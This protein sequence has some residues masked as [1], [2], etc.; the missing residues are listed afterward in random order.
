MIY[1]EAPTPYRPAPGDGP[2][3]FLAGGIT[4]CPDWQADARTL[5]ADAPIVVLNPRR[6]HY[7]PADGDTAEQQ[8][9]WEYHHLHLA[10][11]TLFWFPRCDPRTTVQPITLLELGTALAETRLQGRLITVGADP[12]F[13]RRHDL[14]LQLRHGAPALNLHDTLP[15]TIAGALRALNITA[16]G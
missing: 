13:P 5:L 1:V 7:N 15:A 2:S 8:V 12:D 11:L 10:D 14:H 9:A 3:L 16:P 6:H 4:G